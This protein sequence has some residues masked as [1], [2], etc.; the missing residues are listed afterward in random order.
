MEIIRK[1]FS[2]SYMMMMLLIMTVFESR[3]YCGI[4]VFTTHFQ[5]IGVIKSMFHVFLL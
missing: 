1:M 5:F 4:L 3:A 2:F